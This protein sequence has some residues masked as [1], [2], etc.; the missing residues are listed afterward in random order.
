MKNKLS[1]LVVALILYGIGLNAQEKNV[2]VNQ[3]GQKVTVEELNA[4]AQSLH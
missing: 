1:T 4:E 3:Y 2:T